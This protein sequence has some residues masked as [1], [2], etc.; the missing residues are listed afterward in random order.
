[1]IARPSCLPADK[2]WP[3]VRVQTSAEAPAAVGFIQVTG[4][5]IHHAELRHSVGG[6]AVLCFDINADKGMPF[7]V[8]QAV[9]A[10]PAALRAAEVK[11]AHMVAGA[12]VHVYAHGCRP[13]T[14]HDTAALLLLDVTDVITNEEG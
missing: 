1:M 5:L 7:I 13:R 10:E 2:P 14:D 3:P 8:R 9:P 12:L 11:A 6:A 4:R